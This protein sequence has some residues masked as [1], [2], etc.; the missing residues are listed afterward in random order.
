MTPY[1]IVVTV[2]GQKETL[3]KALLAYDQKQYEEALSLLNQSLHDSI[4]MFYRAESLMA[5][6]RY[7]EAA[8]V[9][10]EVIQ[11]QGV[12]VEVATFH[13]VLALLGAGE[14]DQ[15]QE[16]L[17]SIPESSHYFDDAAALRERL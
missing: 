4:G 13:R 8:S 9:Y 7:A 11:Q 15:A 10:D 12:F 6:D 2:R 14:V 3:D 17:K 16:L 1:D 5:L